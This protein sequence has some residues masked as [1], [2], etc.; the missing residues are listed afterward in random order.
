MFIGKIE[1]IHA[2]KE[3]VDNEGKIDFSKINLL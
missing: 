1:Y 2:D 3:L